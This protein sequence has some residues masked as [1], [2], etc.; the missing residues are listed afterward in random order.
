M[1]DNE[2]RAL[3][4]FILELK[5]KV[6][7]D[8]AREMMSRLVASREII[9]IFESLLTE[10]IE[11]SETGT[12]L[13]SPK[14]SE[15]LLIEKSIPDFIVRKGPHE[16][17]VF[18]NS[19]M[20]KY[21]LKIEDLHL[22]FDALERKPEARAVIIVW[23]FEQYYPS[24]LLNSSMIRDFVRDQKE[25]VEFDTEKI[26]PLD[27]LIKSNIMIP[28]IPT[29]GYPMEKVE[30]RLP[31]RGEIF[32]ELVSSIKS[33]TLE[34]KKRAYSLEHK[35]K[36]AQMISE[37]H[38]ERIIEIFRNYFLRQYNTEE[39]RKELEQLVEFE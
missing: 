18:L 10:G 32:M 31:E 14:V 20:D 16:F 21:A 5:E 7:S 17:L 30:V 3:E 11:V 38:I 33:K 2:N 37:H 39:V 13:V 27:K 15:K 19:K 12:P 6:K 34:V 22:Y 28:T 8:T 1:S 25:V 29:K 4:T 9:E 36:A 24:V 26:Q 23:I 35:Q